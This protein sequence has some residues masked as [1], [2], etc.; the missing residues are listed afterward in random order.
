MLDERVSETMPCGGL[1]LE[2]MLTVGW[3]G[4][5]CVCTG[6][7]RCIVSGMKNVVPPSA[8]CFSWSSRVGNKLKT[9]RSVCPFTQNFP[10][11]NEDLKNR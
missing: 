1:Y 8:T 6:K 9:I 10:T 2:V 5:L 4:P 3:L 11:Q 7:M